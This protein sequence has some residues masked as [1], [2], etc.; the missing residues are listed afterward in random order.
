MGNEISTDGGEMK[1]KLKTKLKMT[2][3]D[4]LAM[5]RCFFY[6]KMGVKNEEVK[7]TD[8]EIL[9]W[10]QI[11]MAQAEHRIDAPLF[12]REHP[13]VQGAPLPLSSKTGKVT[14]TICPIVR[15]IDVICGLPDWRH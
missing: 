9:D 4:L 6:T 11:V 7:P 15:R 5:Y 14:A 1:T 3:S 2:D 8:K 12:M 13:P 10:L